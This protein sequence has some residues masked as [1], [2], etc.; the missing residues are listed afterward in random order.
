[1]R[2]MTRALRRCLGLGEL[3][4]RHALT[5]GQKISTLEQMP[6][7]EVG[8]RPS[9][10]VSTEFLTATTQSNCTAPSRPALQ[11][12]STTVAGKSFTCDFEGCTVKP[13]KRINELTRHKLKH[14][15]NRKIYPCLAVDCTRVGSKGFYRKDKLK[16][17]MVAA[18]EPDTPFECD[19]STCRMILSRDIMVVHT[20]DEKVNAVRG[21]P[22]P[23][24]PFRIDLYSSRSTLTLDDLQSHLRTDHDANRRQNYATLISARGYDPVS[25]NIICPICME[26]PQFSGHIDF[27]HHFWHAHFNGFQQWSDLPTSRRGRHSIY[28]QLYLLYGGHVTNEVRQHRRTLLSLWPAL[29]RF[30]MWED[31][32]CRRC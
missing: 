22:M 8:N 21:C 13:F 15:P 9:N 7:Q 11:Q 29:R 27:Y 12:G 5:K 6:S 28:N 30:P 32:R 18:H 24:C 16:A 19:R 20:A 17:H 26:Q 2:C 25:M 14:N 1:M 3:K 4:K 10:D 31:I 23:Q